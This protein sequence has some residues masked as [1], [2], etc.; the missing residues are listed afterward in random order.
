MLVRYQESPYAL[1]ALPC[2]LKLRR[3]FVFCKEILF[4]VSGAS[5]LLNFTYVI[6]V[7]QNEMTVLYSEESTLGFSWLKNIRIL[8]CITSRSICLYFMV[9]TGL[10]YSKQMEA[11]TLPSEWLQQGNGPSASFPTLRH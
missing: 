4:A 5:W 3:H 6:P 1:V 10:S 8:C 9:S 7:F 2:A 11:L